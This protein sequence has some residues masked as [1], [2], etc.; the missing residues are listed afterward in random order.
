M[1]RETNVRGV[2]ETKTSIASISDEIVR[3]FTSASLARA[4]TLTVNFPLA[5]QNSLA[6]LF[7]MAWT[8]SFARIIEVLVAL[9]N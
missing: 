9:G 5:N 8:S 7:L 3:K 2:Q 1:D 6:N 4:M